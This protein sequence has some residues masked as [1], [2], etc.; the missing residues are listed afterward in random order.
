M[1]H[2]RGI[3]R[4]IFVREIMAALHVQTIAD[5]RGPSFLKP[6]GKAWAA[7]AARRLQNL[8]KDISA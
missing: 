2:A 7:S 5:W 1:T 3:A 8:A 4:W 6:V